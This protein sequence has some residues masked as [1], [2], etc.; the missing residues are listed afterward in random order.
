GLDL[1]IKT[2]AEI[3]QAVVGH[4]GDI[5]WNKE[6]PNG[7]PRKRL[8]ISKLSGLGWTANISLRDGLKEVYDWYKING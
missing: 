5:V 1:Q 8:D 6:M 7:S 3:I 4:E 2:L